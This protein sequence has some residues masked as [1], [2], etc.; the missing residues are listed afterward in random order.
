[1]SHLVASK[2]WDSL[3]WEVQNGTFNKNIENQRK[4]LSSFCHGQSWTLWWTPNSNWLCDK[5]GGEQLMLLIQRHQCGSEP[6]EESP[7]VDVSSLQCLQRDLPAWNVILWIV[8]WRSILGYPTILLPFH[9][10]LKKITA[11]LTVWIS[12][13]LSFTKSLVTTVLG[14]HHCGR[15][16][17][18]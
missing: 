9:L 7:L 2:V 3:R 12:N 5:N 8:A 18:P 16:Q 11:F 6:V 13:S 14:L 10:N 1:M 17:D 4:T 15:W